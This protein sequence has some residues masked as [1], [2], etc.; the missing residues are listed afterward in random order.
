MMDPP[1]QTELKE[2]WGESEQLRSADRLCSGIPFDARPQSRSTRWRY[3]CLGVGSSWRRHEPLIRLPKA[4]SAAA[5]CTALCSA[6]LIPTLP[7]PI[8]C[9]SLPAVP[10]GRQTSSVQSFSEPAEQ[11]GKLT[12]PGGFPTDLTKINCEYSGKQ[13]MQQWVTTSITD[14]AILGAVVYGTGAEIIRSPSEWHRTWLG[15]GDRIGVRYTQAAARGSAELIIGSLIEDDPRHLSYKDDPHTH[16]GVKAS[17][18][19]G[20][21]VTR[22]FPTPNHIGF[23]RVGHAFLDSISVLRSSPCGDGA[24]IPAFDRIVGIWAGAYGGYPWY[25]RAENTLAGA[26]QRAATAF[27]STLAGSFYTEFSP[28]ISLGL[29]KLFGHRNKTR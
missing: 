23:N 27:G 22:S 8:L 2:A 25:P 11:L 6:L 18:K 9:Q 4:A 28:E 15:L 16:Y 29:S 12:C 14:Q 20:A 13:R 17:C 19:S 10:D 1:K 24:R 7:C 3:C 5:F 21:I 26:G